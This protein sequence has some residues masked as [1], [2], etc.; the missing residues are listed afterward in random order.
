MFE[1]KCPGGSFSFGLTSNFNSHQNHTGGGNFKNGN[2][3][4]AY[5]GNI[6]SFTIEILEPCK[7]NAKNVRPVKKLLCVS[8]KV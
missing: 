2:I 8:Y 3:E 7:E 4:G 5:R 6:Q 1:E